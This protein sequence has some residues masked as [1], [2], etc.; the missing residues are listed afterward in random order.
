MFAQLYHNNPRVKMEMSPN[1]Y[2]AYLHGQTLLGFHHGHMTK[3]SNLPQIFA[4]KF[5]KEWGQSTHTYVH[6]G[7]KHHVDEKEYPGLNWIQHPT[8]AA[9]DAYAARGG[10]LSK[11]QAT[12]MTYHIS[13]GEVARGTF[14]PE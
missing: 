4:Q 14:I 8:L 3:A 13:R 6:S 2:V 1:P 12:S 9:P 5:R 11:R 7:H 10:W